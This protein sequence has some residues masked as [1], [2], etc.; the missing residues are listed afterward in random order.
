[1]GERGADHTRCGR[2]GRDRCDV[3]ARRGGRSRAGALGFTTSRTWAH[4]T[5]LGEQIGTL[6]ASTDEVLGIAAALRRAGTGV[7]QLISDVYQSADDEL[8][9]ARA[10]AARPHRARGRPSA[11]LHR[12][13][14]RR[15]ARPLPRAAR[16]RSGSGTPRARTSGRRSRCVRSA[17][18]SASPAASAR[19]AFCPTLPRAARPAARRA[20][21]RTAQRRTSAA[22]ILAEHARASP[23]PTSRR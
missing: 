19:C 9:A 5:S 7:V 1:M 6:R 2:P 23:Q 8:V 21:R 10:R 17:C 15:D 4:R 18:C 14:E 11:E 20:G 3:R 13:A 22:R 16:R 12:A